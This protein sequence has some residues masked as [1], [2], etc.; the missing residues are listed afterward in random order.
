MSDLR[1]CRDCKW[2]S[3]MHRMECL[4]D[5]AKAPESNAITP[6]LLV[7]GHTRMMCTL[8]RMDACGYEGKLWE[9]AT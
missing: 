5:L 2:F 4:H 7:V 3:G 1:F 8:M 9:P 6:M